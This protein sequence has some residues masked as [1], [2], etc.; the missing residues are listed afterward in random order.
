VHGLRLD[1]K[2]GDILLFAIFAEAGANGTGPII[3]SG[4]HGSGVCLKGHI[5]IVTLAKLRH[6]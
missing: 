3:A 4:K 1:K 5:Y 2:L 6:R